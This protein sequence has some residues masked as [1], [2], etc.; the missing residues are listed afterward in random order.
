ME[1][2]KCT[3]ILIL[4]LILQICWFTV[5]RKKITVYPLHNHGKLNFTPFKKIFRDRI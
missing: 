4:L 3:V 1:V 5:Y 2:D